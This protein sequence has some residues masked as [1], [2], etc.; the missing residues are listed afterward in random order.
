MIT[1][2]YGDGY[3]VRR[4]YRRRS[5]RRYTKQWIRK[6]TSYKKGFNRYSTGP[7][8]SGKYFPE[9][10]AFWRSWQTENWHEPR[11]DEI[12]PSGY[13]KNQTWIALCKS[14][15]GFLLAQREGDHEEMK[16][17]AMQIRALQNDLGLPQSH[18]DMFSPEEVEWMERESDV[19]AKEL[20]YA[21]SV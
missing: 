9:K 7:K 6:K 10:P 19:E 20:W 21:T 11:P 18:F 13:T 16:Q 15:N 4:T 14:W 12:L 2:S 17:Y 3:L 8:W 5:G 1:K